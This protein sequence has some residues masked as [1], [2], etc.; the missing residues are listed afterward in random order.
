MVG[1]LGEGAGTM[2]EVSIPQR[3]RRVGTRP[4]QGPRSWSNGGAVRQ[5]EVS[6]AEGQHGY[7]KRFARYGVELAS[8]MTIE[9]VAEHL[10]VSWNLVKGL[11][12][13]TLRRRFGRP[14]LKELRR[15][16]IDEISIGRGHRYLTVVLDLDR[17]AVVFIGEGKG[18]E[19]LDPFWKRLRSARARDPRPS[20]STCLRPTSTRCAP[21]FPRPPWSSTTSMW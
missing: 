13:E 3:P 20:P 12:K 7:T 18:A 19:A 21:T 14:R 1:P 2:I 11:L 6:F 5:A 10:G 9:D 4:R 16:A 15:L 8:H 17:G